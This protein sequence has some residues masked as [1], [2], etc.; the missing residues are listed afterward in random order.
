MRWFLQRSFAYVIS[1]DTNSI[2]SSCVVIEAFQQQYYRRLNVVLTASLFLGVDV[3]YNLSVRVE[4]SSC[5]FRSPDEQF[6]FANR[7]LNIL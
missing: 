5:E 3:E 2:V 4:Q 7:F 6:S 1:H